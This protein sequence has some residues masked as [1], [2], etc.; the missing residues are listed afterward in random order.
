MDLALNY[1]GN[2]LMFG[3]IDS[4]LSLVILAVLDRKRNPLDDFMV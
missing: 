1:P 4:L 3:K 2:L